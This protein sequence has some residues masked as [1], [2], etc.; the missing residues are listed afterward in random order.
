MLQPYKLTAS[1]TAVDHTE[2]NA[3]EKLCAELRRIADVL[4]DGSTYS[5][6]GNMGEAD[7]G[8]WELETPNDGP[9]DAPKT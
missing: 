1:L 5:E 7:M 3:R 8:S 4:E 9:T 2:W 6:S